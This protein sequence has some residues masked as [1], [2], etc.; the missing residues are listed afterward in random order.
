MDN[1]N[2]ITYWGSVAYRT[3]CTPLLACLIAIFLYIIYGEWQGI[4]EYYSS[5]S[6]ALRTNQKLLRPIYNDLQ[7]ELLKSK[8][9]MP[10]NL[11]NLDLSLNFASVSSKLN[12]GALSPEIKQLLVAIIQQLPY[13]VTA[14]NLL[15]IDSYQSGNYVAAVDYW[16]RIIDFALKENLESESLDILSNKVAETRKKIS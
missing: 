6:R 2:N 13:Q 4:P 15:A 5:K 3:L 14:L 10:F 16:E 11:D 8:Y 1:A 12:D 7:R 9:G